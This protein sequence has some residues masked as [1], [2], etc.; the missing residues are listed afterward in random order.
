MQVGLM[1]Y[2]RPVMLVPL[3]LFMLMMGRLL[4]FVLMMGLLLLFVLMMGR[5]LLFL[6][7]MRRLIMFMLMMGRLLLLLLPLL[8]M[9]MVGLLLLEKHRMEKV[10]GGVQLN[11]RR[12]Q[13]V[14][15]WK[16]M[17]TGGM[18]IQPS[19]SSMFSVVLFPHQVIRTLCSCSK[20]LAFLLKLQARVDL[21][22]TQTKQ[23]VP[24]VSQ[25]QS[26][27]TLEA[28]SSFFPGPASPAACPWQPQSSLCRSCFLM[29]QLSRTWTLSTMCSST[30]TPCSPWT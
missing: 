11:T 9:V 23:K 21:V 2:V 22:W 15:W 8:L 3:L 18:V 17:L 13:A 4:L 12:P 27:S 19:I 1:T 10:L 24:L 6:L 28:A 25:W 5:L 20:R 30:A 14:W 7:I 16:V 29:E 26:S